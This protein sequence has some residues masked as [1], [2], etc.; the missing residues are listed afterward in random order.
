MG[1]LKMR[2]YY[3][4]AC[5]FY[6][7]LLTT[8]LP[9]NATIYV[10]GG[11]FSNTSVYYHPGTT[12]GVVSLPADFGIALV[13]GE[14]QYI[15]VLQYLPENKYLCRPYGKKAAKEASSLVVPN[16]TDFVPF[17][18]PPIALLAWRGGNCTFVDKARHAQQ[19]NPNI[20]FLIVA[21][22][23]ED[24]IP[25]EAGPSTNEETGNG[26]W[27]DLALLS[28]TDSVG[29]MLQELAT[30]ANRPTSNPVIIH[31]RGDYPAGYLSAN[32]L[33]QLL[34]T[35]IFVLCMFMSLMG[36]LVFSFVQNNNG[37]RGRSVIRLGQRGSA[38]TG[39]V[40]QV[41]TVEEM[42]HYFMVKEEEGSDGEGVPNDKDHLQDHSSSS[43]CT[44]PNCAICLGGDDEGPPE[45]AATTTLTGWLELPCQHTFHAACVV[46]WLTERH[47]QCPLCKFN[48]YE[49]V[50]E[51]KGFGKDKAVS[52]E[53]EEAATTTHTN[54]LQRS[55]LSLGNV[56][57]SRWT[58]VDE[59]EGVGDEGG[60]QAAAAEVELPEIA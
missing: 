46:P 1:M 50:K 15:A 52:E 23:E 17:G 45:T 57:R 39:E 36:Y 43:C 30:T 4:P 38:S 41:L 48:V 33:Q 55:M 59:G 37:T 6:L 11:D 26:D 44:V 19:L 18:S 25:M 42:E 47:A 29:G 60:E 13:V 2:N 40:K 9:S 21:N 7:F 20:K 22:T 27:I 14:K 12:L 28:V 54:V 3:C 5:F 49:H 56:F 31:I 58:L 8:F 24:L 10:N 51:L 34:L 16:G 32:M 53:H 35:A